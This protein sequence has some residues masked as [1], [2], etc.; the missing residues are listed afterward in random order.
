[1][2]A[3]TFPVTRDDEENVPVESIINPNPVMAVE[4]IGLTPMS[5][6][7][8][9]VPVVEIP[10]LAKAAKFPAN[11][12]FTGSCTADTG[13]AGE[14]SVVR[15]VPIRATAKNLLIALGSFCIPIS[16]WFVLYSY[17]TYSN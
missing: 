7:M 11:P 1:L 14:K 16:L 2:D 15:T 9:V 17:R 6:L 3:Y 8:A 5:P 12:R 13:S 10:D 4:P